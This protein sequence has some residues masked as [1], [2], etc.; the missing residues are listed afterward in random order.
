MYQ[1]PNEHLSTPNRTK[2]VT[3]PYDFEPRPYQLGFWEAVKEYHFIGLVWARRHGKDLNCWNYA[4]DRA[5]REPLDVTY[6]FPTKDM[7]KKNLWKAKTNDGRKFTDYIP[8]AIRQLR[9]STDDGLNDTDHSVELINGSIIR[10]ETGDDPDRLRGANSKLYILS[11]Y[12]E[13]DPRVLDVIEPVV[14]ANGGQIIA[15]FT[16]K[17][18]NHAKGSWDAWKNDSAWWTSLIT[19][20]DTDVFNEGQLQRL[21]RRLIERFRLQGRS[22]VEAISYYMQE[23][24]CSFDTPIIGSY[25]GEALRIAREQG[26]IGIVQPETDLRTD[27]YWDLG[28]DD[29]TSIW[30]V[31]RHNRE[32]RVVDY[33]ENSGEGLAHYAKVL[34][35]KGYVYDEHWAPHDIAVRE[36][37]TGVSRIE[38]S[39]KLGINFRVAPKMPLEDGINATRILLARCWFD[40]E[41][42]K[43]GVQALENYHKDWDE[44][45]MVFRS[46]PKH[47]WSSHG[48]DAMRTLATSIR[49]KMSM[50][51]FPTNDVPRDAQTFGIGAPSGILQPDSS[52]PIARPVNPMY[53]GLTDEQLFDNHGR[54]R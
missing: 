32:V 38:T 31:Q 7:G 40:E 26:R 10:L 24:F 54:M 48:A 35:E 51:S 13:M 44:K 1:N 6:V 11:E 39:K 21:K 5:S 18:A 22:E 42:T 49:E 14:E 47:D 28:M 34:Q 43:R 23:Y 50:S 36:M 29:S 9:N 41:K 33:Y 37:G 46:K 4:I 27:T 16:P 52:N 25:F 17:G 12:A 53:Q 2:V 3:I 30:F 8:M 15:N 45:L 20:D 19:A